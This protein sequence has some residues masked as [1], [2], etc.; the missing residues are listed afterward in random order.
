MRAM[1]L[2]YPLLLSEG[3]V[4]DLKLPNRMLMSPM[5]RFRIDTAGVPTALNPVYYS[6]RASAGL[7]V[8]EGSYV[9]PSGRWSPRAAGLVTDA[10]VAGWRFVT[11]AVRNNGGRMFAQIAHGGRISHPQLQPD[12]KTSPLAPSA[13]P[14]KKKVRLEENDGA[15]V[16]YADPVTPKAMD[17]GDIQ[18]VIAAF[19][20]T[21]A[22]AEEAGFDG[23]EIHAGSGFLHNQFLATCV[24]RRTDAYGGSEANR[25]RFLIETLEAVSEV[26]GSGRVGVK[27]APN[28]AYNDIET[29]ESE[30]IATYTYLAK[31]LSA[32]NL[33]YVHVQYPPWGLFTGPK[34]LNPI[35][36]VREHFR[37][38]MVGAGE[39][40]RH[41][42]EAALKA[43]TCDLIAFGRRFIANP[44]LPERFRRDA[45]ENAWDESKLYTPTAEGFVDYPTLD[46]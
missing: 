20:S 29:S 11:N 37:G 2:V 46:P 36:L 42:A 5:T 13:I 40:D 32:L 25:T 4:G 43:G 41:T 22:R 8:A 16:V 23:V 27:I 7:I 14:Q 6:Q 35:P 15:P 34:T 9:A 31:A 18:A 12:G 38:T 39:F 10:Q 33:G 24:N 19:K 17:R 1:T 21:A 26:R 45:G 30:I 44:D 28:F 3:T